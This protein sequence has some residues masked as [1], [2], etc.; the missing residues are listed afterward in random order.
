MD[1]IRDAGQE[2]EAIML[3]EHTV[4]NREWA[5]QGSALA[6]EPAGPGLLSVTGCSSEMQQPHRPAL[7]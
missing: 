7:S 5:L 2:A 6:R 4:A 1:E 3:H